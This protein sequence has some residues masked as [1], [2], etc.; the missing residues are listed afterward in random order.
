MRI[1][2]SKTTKAIAVVASLSSMSL[3]AWAQSLEEAVAHTLDT[4]P[5]I[6]VV[7]NRF[8]ARQEQVAQ[9]RGGYLPSLDVDAGVGPE[10]NNTPGFRATGEDGV[11][12]TRQEFGISL[13]QMLFDGFETSYNVDRTTAE[14]EAEQYSL[15]AE[16]ENKAL[17]VSE[18]YLQV[19]EAQQLFE[20]SE[21]NLKTH[22]EIHKQIRQRTESGLGSASDLSQ[23]NAR[24]ALARSNLIAARNNQVDAETSFFRVV[25]QRAQ[26]LVQPVADQTMLP[27]S[28]EAAIIQGV[29]FN[30]TLLS[31][32]KDIDAA[33][34]QH[35]GSR[36]NFYPEFTFEVQGRSDND[37]D[38]IEGY[39]EQ[40]A[41]MIRMRY[42]LFNG[43][44]DSARVRET[45]Y[46]IN[47][48]K[49]VNDR[50]YRQLEEGIGL[51]WSAYEFIAEQ[52]TYLKQHV[53]AAFAT[54]EAYK[55]QFKLGKRSLLDLLDTENELFEARRSF[56]VAET[57]FVISQYRLLNASG[58]LL[59]SLRVQAPPKWQLG[60]K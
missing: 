37:I 13:R 17:Q 52:M 35:D 12:E 10:Y 29:E 53:E 6:R 26:A 43:G 16:A 57:E 25:G 32:R 48:A 1:V 21:R 22:L 54:R 15:L 18:V 58:Q 11:N 39:N 5:E 45:A 2:F 19:L 31:A 8:K 14:T 24:V 9:A 44:R 47:E 28:E 36:S 3:P 4:N 46:Q 50:A 23:I 40:L 20:L 41:A 34:A 49:E 30:P 38:G 51:S 27:E 55:K 56:V 60:A 42:N 33:H 59:S 7:F